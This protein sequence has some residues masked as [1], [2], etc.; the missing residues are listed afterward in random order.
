MELPKPIDGGLLLSSEEVQEQ[1]NTIN[2]LTKKA[3][4]ATNN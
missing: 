2:D 4:L 3:M 1:F